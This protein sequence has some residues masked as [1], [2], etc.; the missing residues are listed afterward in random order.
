M[1]LVPPCH[2]WAS[3]LTPRSKLVSVRPEARGLATVRPAGGPGRTDGRRG[4]AAELIV[5]E[6][7]VQVGG[8][9]PEVRQVAGPAVQGGAP[10]AGRRLSPAA[11]KAYVA[12]PRCPPQ[13]C[14]PPMGIGETQGGLVFLEQ[15]TDLGREPAVMSELDR[16]A[17]PGQGLERSVE[18]GGVESEIRRQLQEHGAELGPEA[19]HSF[20]EALDRLLGIAESADV[21]E[22]AA[23]LHGH[24]KVSGNSGGPAG[25]GGRL[26]K[27]VE[28]VIDLDGRKSLGVVVEPLAG[29]Q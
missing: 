27:A 6:V 12:P 25:E 7:D 23:R 18:G 29:R 3:A 22:V 15:A 14:S 11:M 17:D 13:G 16:N 8:R 20:A 21:G 10:V 1:P 5:V 2:T 28:G 24:H 9:R 4:R 19:G 26:R